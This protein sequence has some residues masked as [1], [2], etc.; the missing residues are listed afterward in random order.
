MSKIINCAHQGASALALENTLAAIEL[1]AKLGASW[2]E[3]DLQQTADDELVLFHDNNL[4]RTSTGSGP[5]WKKSLQELQLLDAGS[6]FSSQY[7][8]EP[9]PTVEFIIKTMKGNLNFNIELKLHGHERNLEELMARKIDEMDCANECLVTSFD[10]TTIDRLHRLAPGVKTGYIIGKGQWKDSLLKSHVEILSLEKTM[11]TL[12]R[13]QKAHAEGKKI[14]AWTV[15]EE[16]EMKH[17]QAMKVDA[18]ISNHP[19]RVNIFLN[20]S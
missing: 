19:D 12:E 8:G 2:I 5:L 14:H 17:L 10:H 18:F 15:N 13:V 11:V 20:Q 16:A 4:N 9:I 3:I 1:A 6:W 7:A